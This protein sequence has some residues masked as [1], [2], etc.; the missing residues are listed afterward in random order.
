MVMMG[1]SLSDRG[2]ADKDYVLGCIPLAFLSGL[3]GSSPKGRFTN[4]YVWADVISSLFAS[5]FMIKQIKKKYG[6]TNEEI[7]DAVLTKEKEIMDDLKEKRI[8]D[9]L[10]YDY[11]LDNDLFVKFEGQDFIRSYDEGGLSAYNYAWKLSSSISRFFS[12]IILSTLEEKRKKLLDYDEEHHLSCKQKTQTLVIEWSGANDLI[13]MNARPSIVEVDRAIKERIKNLELLIKNGYRNFIWFNLPDLSLTPRYQN[14]TGK[15]GDL[16]R[17]NAQQCSLYFNQELAN[18]C[19]KLQTM[20]PHCSFDLFDINNVFT[21]A[22]DHPEQYGLDPEKR[23]Q[24]YKTSVDFKILP[25]GTSPAKGY[26]FWDDVHPTADVH[27]ILANEFY[28]KYNPQY[29]FTEPESEDVHEAELNISAADLQKAFCAR[30]DEQ[31]T[32]DQHSFFGRYKKSK[33]NYQTASLEEILK[34]AL[35]EKGTRTQEV[36]KDLQWLD[37]SGNV[38][39]NIPA[40]KEAMMEVDTNKKNT[41]FAV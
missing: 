7:A 10:L 14:M 28:K 19:Q 2:T 32:T 31:L 38:N 9:D 17:A 41:A 40:L 24:P 37:S 29:E 23:K 8:M 36:L 27:A 16:E 21:S 13:T 20:F 11:N 33:I 3:T 30:Y 26:M 22:Y 39:L 15:E 34:H 5:D 1:D 4:G 25:N 35:C 12:R 6:Y 18:A